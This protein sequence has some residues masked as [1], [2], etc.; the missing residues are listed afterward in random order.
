MKYKVVTDRAMTIDY[1][2]VFEADVEREFSESDA[3]WFQHGRGVPL[4]QDNVPKGATVTIIVES[5][6]E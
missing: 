1:L 4:T 5:D 3:A 2:G 6:K